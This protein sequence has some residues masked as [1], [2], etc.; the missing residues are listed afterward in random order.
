MLEYYTN[1]KLEYVK[2]NEKKEENFMKIDINKKKIKVTIKFMNKK[3]SH[4]IPNI[5][6]FNKGITY[7][8]I[9]H[10]ESQI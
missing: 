3:Y 2:I 6:D 5:N 8:S 10:N 4:I 9:V 1:M 7:Y